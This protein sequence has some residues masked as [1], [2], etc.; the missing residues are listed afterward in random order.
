MRQSRREFLKASAAFAAGQSFGRLPDSP[1]ESG[2]SSS[3]PD[4]DAA[5]LNIEIVGANYDPD[6]KDVVLIGRQNH[7]YPTLIYPDDLVVAARAVML[8]RAD[9]IGVSI[10]RD[11][12]TDAQMIVNY[13]PENVA[14]TLQDTRCGDCILTSD[15][16]LKI[17]SLKKDPMTG[18]QIGSAVKSYQSQMDYYVK[19]MIRSVSAD[20][21]SRNRRSDSGWHRLWFEPMMN[22]KLSADGLTMMLGNPV[23]VVKTE[24][25]EFD[26]QRRPIRNMRNL[27]SPSSARDFSAQMTRLLSA[28]SKEQPQL[29]RLNQMAALVK[30]ARW[31]LDI[32]VPI[33]NSRL[34]AYPIVFQPTPRAVPTAHVTRSFDYGWTRYY[35]YLYGGVSLMRRNDYTRR[36][37]IRV[38]QNESSTRSRPGFKV[39]NIEVDGYQYVAASVGSILG[40]R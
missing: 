28:F 1:D 14:G 16:L 3:S 40:V 6:G 4:A 22:V 20:S 32:Q 36:D 25:I 11:P 10:D 33:N 38:N 35:A 7:L 31:M 12:A 37:A 15:V 27:Q 9:A 21:Y 30:V 24:A 5:S 8:S 34:D 17:Y 23:M 18:E 26:A 39:W 13:F 19:E 29:R 2:A